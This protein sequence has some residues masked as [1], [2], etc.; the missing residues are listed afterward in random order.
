MRF[1]SLCSGIEAAS[2]AWNSLGWEAVAFSEIEPFPC[3]VLKHH[4]PDVPNV[5]DMT[6]IKG[7][8]FRG[9]VDLIVGGTP[10]QDF[11]IAGK[12]AGLDGERSGLAMHFIRIVREI[13]PRWFVWENVPGAFSTNGGR[14]FGEFIKALDEFRYGLAWR[15]LDAKFFGTAQR[16]KRVFLIGNSRTWAAPAKVLFEGE[17][18]NAVLHE[19]QAERDYLPCIK[20]SDG[21]LTLERLSQVVFTQEHGFRKL[22][23]LECERLFGFPDGWTD[24][25][26]ASDTARYNA[27]GNSMCVNVMSWLGRRIDEVDKRI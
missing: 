4:F 25:Q 14:D 17:Q 24:V 16:R 6:M 2:C 7:E 20:R 27:L 10:C 15:V 3:R 13:Q 12:R 21:G 18:I 8:E 26:G 9:A 23:P 19:K 5:G 11:S 22:T 1:L